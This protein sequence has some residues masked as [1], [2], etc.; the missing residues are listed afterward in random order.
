M[1]Q[2]LELYQSARTELQQILDAGAKALKPAGLELMPIKRDMLTGLLD[3]ERDLI[4]DACNL[5][6]A[7]CLSYE[8]ARWTI[9]RANNP[10]ELITA[11]IDAARAKGVIESL[12]FGPTVNCLLA[13]MHLAPIAF[14][15][16][17]QSAPD[18]LIIDR[19]TKALN[20]Q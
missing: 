6:F 20:R 16:L 7:A 11:R 13:A 18:L 3:H 14:Y 12:F 1:A 19:C 8:G 10:L 9:D 5:L 4:L 2:E 17:A 15:A